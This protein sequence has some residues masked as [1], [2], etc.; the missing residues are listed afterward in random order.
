[1]GMTGGSR[2]THRIVND[3]VNSGC[4]EDQNDGTYLFLKSTP[5]V[6]KNDAEAPTLF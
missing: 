1:M 2:H 6:S 4:L 3:L 5:S